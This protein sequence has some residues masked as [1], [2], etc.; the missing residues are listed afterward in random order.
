ML[1]TSIEEQR[2]TEVELVYMMITLIARVR[3]RYQKESHTQ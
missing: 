1:I 3:T 2:Y